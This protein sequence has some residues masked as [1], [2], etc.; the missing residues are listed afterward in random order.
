MRK[1]F[2]A[3]ISFFIIF[4]LSLLIV[5][6]Q[7]ASSK[8]GD[9]SA[10]TTKPKRVT[11][12]QNPLISQTRIFAPFYFLENDDNDRPTYNLKKKFDEGAAK[13][14][15]LAF[16]IGKG[17][18]DNPDWDSEIGLDA[19]KAQ[20]EE[21]RR[22][23]GNVIF[24][25]GGRV[26]AEKQELARYCTTI[27]ALQAQYSRIITMFG[28]THLDFDI[29]GDSLPPTCNVQTDQIMAGVD[30]RN[31]VLAGLQADANRN[32]RQLNISFT[33]PVGQSGL[34]SN[35]LCI[36][37]NAR[38]NGVKIAHINLMT[39]FFGESF[40]NVGNL[41]KQS[42]KA[43][44]EQLKTSTGMNGA[45]LWQ[46]IGITP[47]IGRDDEANEIF[48]L[49]DGNKDAETVFNFATDP[50]TPIG[51]L[52]MWNVNRD[53]PRNEFAKYFNSFPNRR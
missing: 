40:P 10:K 4:G 41:T 30:R 35:A 24:S 15:T 18:C 51:F 21:L 2:V 3:A 17:R 34:E 26:D 22:A 37:E 23:G 36:I 14:F 53:Q 12:F 8:K 46:M 25:F 44:Y 13:V 50:Q 31:K 27:P 43:S 38:T 39:M 52:S 16:I 20:I 29:E 49:H 11:T 1:I 28:A 47:N 9:K 19:P 32:G 33:L 5:P 48:S 7:K 45:A 42:V 6:A